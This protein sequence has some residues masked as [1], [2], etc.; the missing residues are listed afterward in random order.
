MPKKNHPKRIRFLFFLLLFTAFFCIRQTD[1]KSSFT[2]KA[3][4]GNFAGNNDYGGGGGDSSSSSDSGD[5]IFNMVDVIG[6]IIFIII[7]IIAS[8]QK[9]S[10]GKQPQGASET[11]DSNLRPMDTYLELDPAFRKT[12]FEEKM[13]NLYIQMQNGW[14]QKNIESIKPYF[15]DAFYYQCD[16]Q[17]DELRRNGMTNYIERIAVLEVTARGF[18][19]NNGMDYIILKLRTRIIDYTLNDS[20]GELVSGSK[21]QEKFMEYEWDVCRK[22]GIVT[23]NTDGMRSINC[24]HCGAPL[25]I[26]QTARCEYCGSVITVTNE[27][28]ALTNI[29]GISQ[30]TR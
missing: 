9:G 24:P 22:S 5:G 21:N 3:D 4:F 2:R 15:T 8:R 12:A 17:L 7:V 6:F 18:Y 16:R 25:T 19:Q 1:A 26:N 27:D 14:Q 13:A 30:Q 29:K 20:T 10:S 28:W 11:P 23:T